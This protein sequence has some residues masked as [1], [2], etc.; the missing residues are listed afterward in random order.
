MTLK[1][2][3]RHR[4]QR[5]Y[6]RRH[7]LRREPRRTR[8][9]I[10]VGLIALLLGTSAYYGGN[11]LLDA[12]LRS[13]TDN[14]SVERVEDWTVAEAPEAMPEPTTKESTDEEP[15]E[16]EDMAQVEDELEGAPVPPDDPTM[17]L[18]IPKLGISHALVA[19]GEVGLEL[20]AM[21]LSETGFPWEKG[22]NAYIA[23]HRIGF[24]GTGSDHIF[25]NLP[26]LAPG[27][28]VTLA[29]SLGQAYAYRVSEILQVDP[30]DLSVT[31]P[32]GRDVV[33][34]QTCI[35]DYGDFATLG[36]N[37]NVRLIVRADRVT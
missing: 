2:K 25:F 30:S 3:K 15:P 37:W 22:A 32:I 10:L 27:D 21:H 16:E 18:S 14:A 26:S 36:P 23:G 4:R 33:S 28:E 11:A 29:D 9:F 12:V 6:Y 31:G 17:Y 24:P 35:E 1:G 7:A 19:N 20:G 13:G 8:L 5:A 34:L